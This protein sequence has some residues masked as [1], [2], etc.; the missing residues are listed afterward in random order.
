MADLQMLAARLTARKRWTTTRLLVVLVLAGS[1]TPTLPA[2]RSGSLDE[3]EGR[4]AGP[5]RSCVSLPPGESLRPLDQSTLAY[6]SGA[7]LWISRLS[8]PCRGLDEVN[9]IIVEQS[10]SQ[11]CRGDHVRIIQHPLTAPGP[12]CILGEFIPYR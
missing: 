8:G 4:E 1:C 11:A 5:A 10:G 12:I 7:I 2:S 6:R 9:T 3:L